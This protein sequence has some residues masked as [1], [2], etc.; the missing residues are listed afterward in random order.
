MPRTT[1]ERA[2]VALG[3]ALRDDRVRQGMRSRTALVERIRERGGS[4][5]ERTAGSVERGEIAG[6]SAEV[7]ADALGWPM[8]ATSRILAGEDPAVVLGRTSAARDIGAAQV[9]AALPGV[10][11]WA[12]DAVAVGGDRTRQAELVTAAR[13][14]ADSIPTRD[15]YGLAAYR[16]HAEGEGPAGDD[17][18]RA[19]A[20]IEEFWRDR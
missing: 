16:P 7:M 1:P 10:L 19:K 11:R 13:Q 12:E 6:D 9:I 5:S 2:R 8:G 17:A 20:A 15:A 14:L 3:R 18:A 4:L